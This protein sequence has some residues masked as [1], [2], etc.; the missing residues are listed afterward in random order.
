MI[1][2]IFWAVGAITCLAGTALATGFAWVWWTNPAGVR[3]HCDRAAYLASWFFAKGYAQADFLEE[4]NRI[5]G[6]AR[7]RRRL[8]AAQILADQQTEYMR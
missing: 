6:L 5:R 8:V 4:M 1:D 3:W 2:I 7:E